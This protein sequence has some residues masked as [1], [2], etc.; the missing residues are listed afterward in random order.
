[1]GAQGYLFKNWSQKLE[2][3]T[4]PHPYATGEQKPFRAK[5][6]RGQ[7]KVFRLVPAFPQ[8]KAHDVKL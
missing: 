8:R 2:K 3:P 5:I 7:G 1:M 6:Q 4:T